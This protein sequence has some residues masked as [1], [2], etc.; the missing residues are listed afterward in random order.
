MMLISLGLFLVAA[1]V[2]S[3]GA[4][5]DCPTVFADNRINQTIMVEAVAHGIHSITVKDI[6]YYFDS[7]FPEAN[8][9][10]T[11]NP[12]F[13]QNH[14]LPS[15]PF[16]SQYETPGM[17]VLDIIMS[18]DD[19]SDQYMAHGASRL[20]KI[21]HGMHMLELWHK[22]SQVYGQLNDVGDDLC[23]CLTDEAGN[24]ILNELVFISNYMRK[25][26]EADNDVDHSNSGTD[27]EA[28][29]PEMRNGC[30]RYRRCPG[31]Y[32]A[33]LARTAEERDTGDALPHLNSPSSWVA[34][35]NMLALSMLHPDEME[36]F[37]KYL[38]CKINQYK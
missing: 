16:G 30:Y 24:G 4:A 6:R 26:G 3:Q 7:N 11:V 29:L 14:T 28:A 27:R 12:D 21:A 5:H 31:R 20:E 17:G 38:Y 9:I 15:A 37:A 13:T 22:A 23:S 36:Y 19:G 32:Q 33:A 18:H 10:P 2:I 34:W 35:K 1:A 8:N 25:F